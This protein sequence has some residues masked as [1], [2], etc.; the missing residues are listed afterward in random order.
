MP[1][2]TPVSLATVSLSFGTSR[3]TLELSL[4]LKEGRDEYTKLLSSQPEAIEKLCHRL[5]I[6]FRSRLTEEIENICLINQL[7]LSNTSSE[8]SST[9]APALLD[10]TCG[11]GTAVRAAKGSTPDGPSELSETPLRSERFGTRT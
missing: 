2:E 8:C 9:T 6:L 7:G 3:I 5:A 1:S 4:T 11:S 10:P